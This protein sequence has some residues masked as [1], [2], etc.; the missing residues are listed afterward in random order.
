M[1]PFGVFSRRIVLKRVLLILSGGDAGPTHSP[2][3]KTHLIQGFSH[4]G[5]HALGGAKNASVRIIL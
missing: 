2:G 3:A 5:A 1:H 4:D